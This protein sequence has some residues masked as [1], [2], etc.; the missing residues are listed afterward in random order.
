MTAQ[1]IK[2]K[3][4]NLLD[5]KMELIS[6]GTGSKCLGRNQLTPSG[7]ICEVLV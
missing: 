2:K 6:L 3:Q 4:I 1:Y 5:R 7:E